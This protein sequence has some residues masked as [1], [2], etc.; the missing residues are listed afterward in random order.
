MISKR[1]TKKII[2]HVMESCNN[3]APKIDS[4]LYPMDAQQTRDILHQI[5]QLK[6][7]SVD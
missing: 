2:S 4:K 3:V 7:F 1:K 6:S 5:L